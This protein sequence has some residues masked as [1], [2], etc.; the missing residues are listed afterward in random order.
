MQ[1]TQ[2]EKNSI[3]HMEQGDV[4]K[5]EG[6]GKSNYQFEVEKLSEAEYRVSKLAL[7]M[8]LDSDFFITPDEVINAIEN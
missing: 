8:C 3:Y 2:V 6:N 5:F 7:F 4:L 1:L